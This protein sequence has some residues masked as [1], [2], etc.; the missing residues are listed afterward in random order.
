MGTLRPPSNGSIAGSPVRADGVVT[1]TDHDEGM[2]RS[3]RR[4]AVCV[5]RVERQLAGLLITLTLNPDIEEMSS[6]RSQ[7]TNEIDTAMATI[8]QFLVDFSGQAPQ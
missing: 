5:V 3:P 1:V 6:Q 7:R 2:V 8:R 4:T